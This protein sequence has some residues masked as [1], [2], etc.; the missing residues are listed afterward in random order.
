VRVGIDDLS[1]KLLVVSGGGLERGGV[2]RI[3][4]IQKRG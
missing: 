2:G 4:A 1:Q 3:A